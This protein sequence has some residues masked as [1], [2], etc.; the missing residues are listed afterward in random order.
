MAI[1]SQV[2][3]DQEH[4]KH[5]TTI[6]VLSQCPL[7]QKRV[8]SR[9]GKYTCIKAG[10]TPLIVEAVT[11][12]LCRQPHHPQ[13]LASFACPLD[14]NTPIIICNQMSGEERSKGSKVVWYKLK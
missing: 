5:H 3:G 11:C 2:P 1:T 13:T 8:I 4:N 14:W 12:S 10:V 7:A 9:G 6:A